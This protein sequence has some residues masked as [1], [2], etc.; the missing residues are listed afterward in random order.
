VTICPQNLVRGSESKRLHTAV[1]LVEI[2]T[3]IL[4]E[5]VFAVL[6]VVFDDAD[7]LDCDVTLA[8]DLLACSSANAESCS[9]TRVVGSI[10]PINWRPL[11]PALE[12]FH[13][14][15]VAE[16]RTPRLTS[17]VKSTHSPVVSLLGNDFKNFD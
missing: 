14:T 8:M 6:P 16:A 17:E 11:D 4:P 2:N 9:P 1:N 5:N 13:A 10:N 7:R 15:R 3:S 12:Q